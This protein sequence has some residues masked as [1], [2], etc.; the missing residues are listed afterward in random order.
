MGDAWPAPTEPP[1]AT[2]ESRPWGES[3]GSEGSDG[4]ADAHAAGETKEDRHGGGFDAK[5]YITGR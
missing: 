2:P 5:R 3:G 1:P 4:R